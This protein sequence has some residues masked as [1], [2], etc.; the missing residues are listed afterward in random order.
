MLDGQRSPHCRADFTRTS[1]RKRCASPRWAVLVRRR[2]RSISSGRCEPTGGSADTSSRGTSTPMG[3][4]NRVRPEAEFSLGDGQLSVGARA[5]LIHEG[6]IAVDGISLTVRRS[7]AGPVRHADRALHAGAIRTCRRRSPARRVNLE[8]DMVGKYVVR[9]AEADG[10]DPASRGSSRAGK[11]IMM[12]HDLTIAKGVSEARSVCPDRRRGRGVP[13]RPHDH[14]RR[15]R[16]PRERGRSHD[17]RRE[18][19]AGGDQ[20]HGA[21][22]PRARSACR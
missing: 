5:Y 8:C 15:R 14:R 19:D 4:S 10:A 9:A 7:D 12:Q 2:A 13:R 22:R 11:A 6:S 16:R 18:G 21:V 17:R 1:D 3:A 20:F